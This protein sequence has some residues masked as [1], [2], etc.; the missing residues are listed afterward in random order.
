[1]VS[2]PKRVFACTS[3]GAQHPK[4]LGR[5]PDCGAWNALVEEVVA[6]KEPARRAQGAFADP[7]PL[8]QAPR[9][10]GARL[11]TGIAELDR[12]LG[13]GFVPASSVLVGGDPG[14][15]KSTLLLQAAAALARQGH[16]CLYWTAEESP[17]QV[18]MRAERLQALA[19]DVHVLHAA[20]LE[21]GEAALAAHAYA[22]VVVD[23]IQ[24]V[25]TEA[26]TSAPG[27]VAQVRECAHRLARLAKER[28]FALALVG[29]VT[30]EGAIAGPKVLEH[31]VDTVL[32]F[33]GDRGLAHRIL[34]AVKNRFGAAGEVGVFEMGDAGLRGVDEVSRFFLAGRTADAS[35]VVALAALEG[36]RALMVEVQALVAPTAFA[37]AKRTAVGADA[38]RLMMLAALMEQRLGLA[39]SQHDIYLNV[40]GGL[41]LVE[42][43]A[44]LAVAL[45][46]VSSLSDAPL[47]GDLAVFG[48]VGLAGELR[49]VA[50]P[51][52][53]VHEAA[54]LGFRRVLLPAASLAR[55]REALAKAKLGKSPE[56]LGART[57]KEAL[58]LV[59]LGRSGLR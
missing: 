34:R 54:R 14:I 23:S 38:A 32:L 39:F 8:P 21:A 22:F 57:L 44:D 10:A 55:V 27:T 50:Q 16:A 28:G 48:E 45:A 11:A 3:C 20:E 13:G 19:E 2:K 30:K 58:E 17:A 9:A 5:C 18:R 1:M 52:A 41:R 29:H 47:G 37:Q 12:V 35:G 53:R 43:A 31:L 6:S 40:A 49:P 56:L 7:M 42:P 4:W 24:T 36:T 51:Q 15:G 59:G 25:F 33:E 26:L 46:L